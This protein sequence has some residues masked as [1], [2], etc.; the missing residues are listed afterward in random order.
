MG[1]TRRFVHFVGGKEA[2]R[3]EA[4]FSDK[5]A[6]IKNTLRIERRGSA[7]QHGTAIDLCR[8]EHG[9]TTAS[10]S[11]HGTDDGSTKDGAR[12]NKQDG[13]GTWNPSE[14]N[15]VRIWQTG[16][17]EELLAL[18][19]GE[20]V[21]PQDA[22]AKMREAARDGLPIKIAMFEFPSSHSVLDLECQG[23]EPVP[24]FMDAIRF[25][26]TISE[27]QGANVASSTVHHVTCWVSPTKGQV[28]QLGSAGGLVV[29]TQRAE[30]APPERM[31][32]MGLFEWALQRL[33][34]V[35]FLAWMEEIHI[36][37]LTGLPEN[38]QQ[39]KVGDGEYLLKR[40]I[41][42]SGRDALSRLIKNRAGASKED[43]PYLEDSPLLGIHGPAIDGLIARLNLGPNVTRWEAALKV[44]GFVFEFIKDKCLDVGFASAPEVARMPRG[45]CTEHT[46][47]MVAMLRRLGAPARARLGWAALDM[48]SDTIFGLHAWAEVK[49]GQRW[50]PIDP[51]FG[52]APAGAFRVALGELP[53]DSLMGPN[54][55]SWGAWLL[56]SALGANVVVA[57]PSPKIDNNAL[58]IGGL[59]LSAKRG[60]W[61]L[62]NGR[63]FLAHPEFGRIE[64]RGDI[65]RLALPDAKYIHAPSRA[66]KNPARH[67]KTLAQ[68]AIDC[69][70][71][72]WL[73]LEGLSEAAALKI[74]REIT[75]F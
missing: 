59:S 18:R 53:L 17:K 51:T 39:K 37:G 35:P 42:P 33:P 16:G 32:S 15:I 71:G 34:R 36:Q 13:K 49:I 29:L 72:R 50:I 1:Q 19:G 8:D 40:A 41:A 31:E 24:P 7:V 58:S 21:W 3:I 62:E 45:D 57:A 27:W 66:G 64:A 44:N 56:P 14:P 4:I 46:V 26:G 65:R 30:A 67:T 75:V 74:L 43:A 73:Y 22:D 2:G 9:A 70:E 48:D 38:E 54:A 69:G 52:Q 11:T 55:S 12:Q 6:S 68:L 20:L 61:L 60:E 23:P 10:W 47:L 25:S 5:S 63:A 28:K